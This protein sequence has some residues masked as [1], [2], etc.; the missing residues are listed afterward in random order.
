MAQSFSASPRYI[1]MTAEASR[2]RTQ[3]IDADRVF[4]E[5]SAAFRL[6]E[7]SREPLRSV[8]YLFIAC[9]QQ[10]DG[11]VRAKHQAIGTELRERY[12]DG[13]LQTT[14]IPP[15]PVRQGDNAR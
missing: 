14:D 11:P 8:N 12:I 15:V 1:R 9:G 3:S 6:T 10:A 2:L 7:R 5:N 13:W 4:A